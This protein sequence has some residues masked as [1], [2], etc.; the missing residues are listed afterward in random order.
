MNDVTQQTVFNDS[1]GG[2][3][4]MMDKTQHSKV[5]RTTSDPRFVKTDPREPDGC[6][7]DRIVECRLLQ[8]T[9]EIVVDATNLN[10]Q[11]LFRKENVGGNKS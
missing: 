6:Y 9:R 4:R 3:P 5:I 10:R 1:F 8:D 2:D 7:P 11:F